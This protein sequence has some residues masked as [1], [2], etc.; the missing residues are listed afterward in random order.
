MQLK[1]ELIAEIKKIF[2]PRYR[3]KL[4]NK[5]ISEIAEE[6]VTFTTVMLKY[7]KNNTY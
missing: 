4:T 6:L 3:R 1:K 2:E 5:E 7:T